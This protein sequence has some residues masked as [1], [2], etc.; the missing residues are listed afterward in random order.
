MLKPRD[1][2]CSH[3]L[4]LLLLQHPIPIQW[5]LISGIG[6]I[7]HLFLPRLLDWYTHFTATQHLLRRR[8]APPDDDPHVL[9]ARRVPCVV[10]YLSL[11][12]AAE[13]GIL[14]DGGVECGGVPRRE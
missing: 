1:R 2:S 14:N 12:V 9:L 7:H 4:S 5:I 6:P 13:G 11:L 3:H 8:R 10:D